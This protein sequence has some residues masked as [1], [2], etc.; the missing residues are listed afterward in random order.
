[1]DKELVGQSHPEDSSQQ[2]RAMMEIGDSGCP[3]GVCT[4]SSVI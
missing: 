3:S 4:G 1:M 2:L